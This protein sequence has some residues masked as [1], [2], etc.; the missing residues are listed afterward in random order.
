MLGGQSQEH[1]WH[2]L[3]GHLAEVV[4]LSFSE[5]PHLKRIRLRVIEEDAQCPFLASAHS[6]ACSTP[7]PQTHTHMHSQIKSN[8]K[9]EV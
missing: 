2:W 1:S 9:V 5:T 6:H 7:T 4:S 3:V 8:E